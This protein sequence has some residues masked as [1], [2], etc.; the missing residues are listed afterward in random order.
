MF[1]LI[2]YKYIFIGFSGAVTLLAVITMTVFGFRAGVDLNGGT[3][4]QI[5]LQNQASTADLENY[6]RNSLGMEDA[7]VA[8]DSSGQI[9][10]IR[11]KER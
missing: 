6:L 2:K 3:L 9:F 11:T 7:G 8:K 4:W 10:L 5:K 1:D